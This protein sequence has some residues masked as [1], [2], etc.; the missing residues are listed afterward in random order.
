MCDPPR[1]ATVFKRYALALRP[2][3]PHNCNNM[4]H[5]AA[6]WYNL[7][8]RLAPPPIGREREAG[9]DECKRFRHRAKSAP[10]P[11][12][13]ANALIRY[14]FP[15]SAGPK[16]GAAFGSSLSE[17]LQAA[18]DRLRDQISSL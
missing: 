1:A 17:N 8:Q 12:C 15:G 16:T 2:D 3:A 5:T 4:T 7:R 14:A 18:H 11:C 13:C 10:A 9:T 6:I